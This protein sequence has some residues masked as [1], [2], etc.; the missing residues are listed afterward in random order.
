MKKYKLQ[1]AGCRPSEKFIDQICENLMLLG[2]HSQTISNIYYWIDHTYTLFVKI[3]QA[4]M[5][6]PVY[7]NSKPV[8]STQLRSISF[9]IIFTNCMIENL[10]NK[11]SNLTL[12]SHL[13]SHINNPQIKN[14]Y[15]VDGMNICLRDNFVFYMLLSQLDPAK[16]NE[17]TDILCNQNSQPPKI[18]TVLLYIFQH[19]FSK[20]FPNSLFIITYHSIDGQLNLHDNILLVGVKCM[21]ELGPN[22]LR[23]C[24]TVLRSEVDDYLLVFLYRF[25][26][27]YYNNSKPATFVS[28]DKF[29]WDFNNRIFPYTQFTIDDQYHVI[30]KTLNYK[31]DTFLPMY[32]D[33]IPSSLRNEIFAIGEYVKKGTVQTQFATDFYRK[34]ASLQ[35][36]RSSPTPSPP[37]PYPLPFASIS[38]TPHPTPYLTPQTS[39]QPTSSRTSSRQLSADAPE[40]VPNSRT[41]TPITPPSPFL[42]P[43]LTLSLPRP[44]T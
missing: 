11:Y 5:Q 41:I 25:I 14:I 32:V 21:V 43:P 12:F 35:L 37:S 10:L 22:D 8:N 31:Y 7:Q 23:P 3:L 15:L 39:S 4:Y 20:T 44:P 17:L 33:R 13:F 18:K 40:F 2:I 24:F 28:G 42:L 6:T 34:C 30:A 19:I 1:R 29:D 36:I 9:P 27:S 38:H 26:N 16:L